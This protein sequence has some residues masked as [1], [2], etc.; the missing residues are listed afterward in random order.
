MAS[1]QDILNDVNL[2]YRNTFSNAQKIVW[3]N[4]ELRE[5]FDVLEIDSPPYAFTTVLDNN[6]YPFPDGLDFTKIK[7]VNMEID[8]TSPEPTFQEVPMKRNDDNVFSGNAPWYTIVSNAMFLYYPGGVPDGMAVYIYLDSEPIEVT[9]SILSSTPDLP[10]KYHEI[11]KFGI[12]KRMASA[13][14]DVVMKNNY[15]ADYQEKIADVLWSRRI[16]EPEF[17]QPT[18]PTTFRNHSRVI[19]GW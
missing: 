4:E 5:L 3:M 14:K 17:T 11:L 2:R 15:E 19:N 10:T 12:L 18:S 9:E 1:Y 8:E 13:R 6:Y 7:V 16:K